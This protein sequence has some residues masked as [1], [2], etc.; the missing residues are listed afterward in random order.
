MSTKPWQAQLDAA[1]AASM[2]L[3]ITALLSVQILSAVR[4]PIVIG[5]DL[6]LWLI[7]CDAILIGFSVALVIWVRSGHFPANLNYPIA[8]VGFF[9]AGLKA[10]VV[11]VAQ[12]DPLPFIIAVT[13]LAGS[14][15]FLSVRYLIISMAL[16]LSLWLIA[17]LQVLPL[18]AALMALVVPLLGATL[19]I[20]VLHRRILAAIVIFELEQ[21]VETLESILPMCAN[22]KKTRDHTG[23]WQS[24]EEYIQD[25]QEGTQIS[26]GSCPSC[27]EE[28][29][30][31]YL[32]NR[33][34]NSQSQA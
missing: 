17:A 10:S 9:A 20:I 30:G 21:R 12:S 22:C 24:I 16:I 7:I 11:V 3:I 1:H 27:H 28:L 5:W 15:C 14:L 23:K 25:N 8:A 34:S 33:K 31:D 6:P 2:P 19:S 29:Y 32:K 13:L 18:T 26:H 4:D